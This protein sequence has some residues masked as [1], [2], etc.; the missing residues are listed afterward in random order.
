MASDLSPG[1]VNDSPD[2]AFAFNDKNF[3]DRVLRIE[4][5]ADFFAA[6]IEDDDDDDIDEFDEMGGNRK[7]RREDT[8]NENVICHEEQILNCNMSD[9]EDGEMGANQEND[10]AM[11]EKLPSCNSLV[12]AQPGKLFAS[13]GDESIQGKDARWNRE[14]P[15]VL[16][17]NSIHISSPILAAKS[18]FFY[19]LFSEGMR[20]PE[21]RQVTLRI[22]ASEEAALME[23]L[24]YMYSNTLST[25]APSAL[26]DILM[27]A[28]KYEVASCMRY[29][30]RL[31]RNVPMTCES[32]LLYLDL[33]GV[34]TTDAVES[35]TE[36]AKH[37]LALRYKD[38]S[39]FIEEVLKLP[40]AGIEAVLS[41]DDL[42][43]ASEDVVYDLVLKWARIQYPKLE[44]RREILSQRLIRVIRFPYMTCR[45]LKKALT[46]SDFN[47]EMVSKVV[48]EALF[49]KA[50]APYRQRLLAAE[51]GNDTSYHHFVERAYKYR[52]VKVI[53]FEV[54]RQQCVV[55]LDLK[56]EECTNLFPAGRVYSQAFHLGGQ[57]FFLSAHCNMDQQSSFHCFGLFLGM[58]EKGSVSFAVDYEF[59]ARSKQTEGYHSKYKGNYTFTGGKAVGYRNL[60]AVP[61]TSFMA[62]DGAYFINGILHLRAE[63]TIRK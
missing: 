54:P 41:S 22:Q 58:Q 57:G 14:G 37:F 47:A 62:E 5:V 34:L 24:N 4:I 52:P 31:L 63:L 1:R 10:V 8:K 35:L 39:K 44:E 60:F 42:Q 27:A 11:V 21:Q 9:T 16:R 30:S 26:L 3:S 43:V 36:A 48:L 18:P 55:Y 28:D 32:A 50:E 19:R 53:E 51:E 40:S 49:F 33:P 15:T 59:S 38:I 25:T 45:K 29:C 46:C 2:F 23:L 13:A 7:R 6:K 17:V 12:S 56:R 61:W 20:E